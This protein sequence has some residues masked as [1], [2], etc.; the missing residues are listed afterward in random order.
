MVTDRTQADV[1]YALAHPDSTTS[2]KGAYNYTDL[3]RV[4]A[5]VD[6]LQTIL[7]T[8]NYFSDTLTV[9]TNWT[10]SDKFTPNNAQ[11]Y[12]S[13]V[14]KIRDALTVMTSTPAVPGTMQGFTYQR[15]NDIEQVLVDIEFLINNI[16]ASF[17]YSGEV[18][19]GEVE[20]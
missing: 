11:R 6:E 1:T 13:N 16:I 12:L 4:E 3:N 18:N 5:K 17:Y 7:R 19:S 14:K 20:S 15:A 2:L 9:K 10:Y 8:Y